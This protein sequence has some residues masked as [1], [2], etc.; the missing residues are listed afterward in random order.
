MFK[1]CEILFI[2]QEVDRI[3]AEVERLRPFESENRN[4]LE[5][6]QVRCGKYL[7]AKI[8]KDPCIRVTQLATNA[9][10]EGLLFIQIKLFVSSYHNFL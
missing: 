10:R 1:Q 5:K 3:V 6:T 7:L 9:P 8:S 2:F 4:L